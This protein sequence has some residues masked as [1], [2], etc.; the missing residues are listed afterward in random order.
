LVV[1][2]TWIAGL[3]QINVKNICSVKKHILQDQMLLG[4]GK[5]LIMAVDGIDTVLFYQSK[6]GIRA[7]SP[8]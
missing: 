4:R 7:F 3:I 8:K 6:T 1:F 2:W 5:L